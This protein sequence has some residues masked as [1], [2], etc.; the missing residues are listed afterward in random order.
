[1][2]MKNEK[3]IKV[4]VA[5]N[6]EFA[7]NNLKKFLENNEKIQLLNIADNG[8]DAYRI[9]IDEVPDIVLIDVILP[10]MDGF[11]VIE[12]T[13]GNRSIKKKPIFI[14]ISS[15]GNQSMVE[16]ACKL[17]VHYYIMKPY[18]LDSVIHRIFQAMLVRRKA[19]LQIKEKERRYSMQKYGMNQYTENTL[20]NDV[21][22]IIRE[23]GIPAHIKGY[24]YIREAIMMTVN[25]INLLNYITKLLYPTIAK[26]YKTTSSSVERAIRHAIE[27][28]WNKGQI[29]VL[30]DM[31]GY[32]ISAGKGKPTNSEFIA[33]IADKL[34]LEYRMNA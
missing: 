31:F 34:R 28:A 12:K 25:D 1:M 32:T 18:N 26:K 23:I 30:E 7:R 33:L 20:E 9:I 11:T 24:Q 13:N 2:N 4:L 8:K 17:G 27:V 10:V 21:T 3:K 19:E 15:M 5:D 14:V 6:S 22:H 29:D 16:Y